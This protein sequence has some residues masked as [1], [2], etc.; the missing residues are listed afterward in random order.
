MLLLMIVLAL[1]DRVSIV[2]DNLKAG[3]GLGPGMFII[4]NHNITN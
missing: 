4:T 3:I 1:V 2:Y